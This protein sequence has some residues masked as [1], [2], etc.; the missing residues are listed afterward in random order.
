MPLQTYS[1]DWETLNTSDGERRDCNVK[2]SYD[3][4]ESESTARK[5][6]KTEIEITFRQSHDIDDSYDTVATAIKN[7]AEVMFEEAA[8]EVAV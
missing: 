4:D 2:L 1:V 8:V 3:A 6:S 5:I 7:F